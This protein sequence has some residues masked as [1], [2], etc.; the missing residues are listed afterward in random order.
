M[1]D[2]AG[3]STEGQVG[4]PRAVGLFADVRCRVRA[5]RRAAIVA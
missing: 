2:H 3:E 4:Q 1:V 5:S